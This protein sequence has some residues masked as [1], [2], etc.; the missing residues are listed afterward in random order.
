MLNCNTKEICKF[1]SMF[2]IDAM[3]DH[4]DLFCLCLNFQP[5]MISSTDLIFLNAHQ[6]ISIAICWLTEDF[7]KRKILCE[8]SV[9]ILTTIYF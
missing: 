1:S 8:F 3:I 5:Q 2:L 9:V 7:I 4:I 6:I